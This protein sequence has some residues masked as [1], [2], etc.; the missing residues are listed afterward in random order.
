MQRR[1]ILFKQFITLFILFGLSFSIVFG[2]KKPVQPKPPT[3]SGAWT[4]N[5]TFSRTQTMTDTKVTPRV[6]ARGKDTRSVEMKLNY[7]ASVAVIESPEKNG[8][9]IGKGS[10]NSTFTMTEKTLAEEENSCDRGKTFKLMTGNFTNMTQISGGGIGEASVWIGVNSD[11][12]YAV[13]VGLPQVPGQSSGS[14]S[15]SYSGQCTLKPGYNIASP[16]TPANVQGASFRS[17]GTNRVDPSNPNQLSGSWSETALGITNTIT[18]SLQR[19]GGELRISDLQFEDMKFPNLN[20]WQEIVEQKGTIDGNF[21]KVKAKVLNTSPQT[22][23]AE[24]RFKETYK[25]DKYDGARPDAP[26]K[27]QVFSVRVEPNSEETVEFVWDSSGYAWF[28]DGRPRLLQRIK[29]ELEEN[30]KKIDE[31]TKNLKVAPKP[32]VLVHGLW[33]DWQVWNAWQN[34]LTTTHSYDWK[35]FPV[36]EKPQKGV[37]DTGKSF[38]SAE[39]T[40]SIADNAHA[41]ESYVE[42]AQKDRN[43][44][45]VDIVAHSSGGLISRWYIDQLMNTYKDYPRPRVSHLVMLGTPNQGSPC[46]DVMWLAFGYDAL[47]QLREEYVAGFNK[48]HTQRK[49]VKFSSLA[50]TPLPIMCKRI[51]PNDSFV[52]ILSALWKIKDTALTK[53]L[54]NEMTGTSDFSNFVKPH[55]AIGPKGNHNPEMPDILLNKSGMSVNNGVMFTNVSNKSESRLVGI[56]YGSNLAPDFSK[57]VKLAAGQ[58]V[59]IE[60]PVDAAQNFGLTFMADSQISATL[61][62]EKGVIIG[63]SLAKTP[64]ASGWFRSIFY[65]KPTTKATWNLKLENTSEKEFEAI[66]ATWKNA[67]K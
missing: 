11:G 21:V 6:S 13:G 14:Q 65:D 18:W 41:L 33:N 15:G 51:V 35:A 37:M 47:V 4:G 10:V 59:E 66:L 9:S 3:C 42:Y 57:R 28:D 40:K 27:D 30:N 20:N 2:Q 56:A 64:E 60:I 29:A 43:A 54:S 48:V 45:H 44:W 19:C 67:V 5:I 34:I 53:S 16:S 32:L 55:V 61:F 62:D 58:S 25:G 50:G 22:K 36:G 52:S 24:L 31:T 23:L 12:T 17:N 8:S 49:G 46:A 7:R 39:K 38:M 26:L 1:F 63:K